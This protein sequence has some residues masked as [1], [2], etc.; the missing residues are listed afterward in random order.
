VPNSVRVVVAVH[1]VA[2]QGRG[3]LHRTDSDGVGAPTSLTS[4]FDP[5]G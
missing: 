2:L 1:G 4:R 3:W 5:A